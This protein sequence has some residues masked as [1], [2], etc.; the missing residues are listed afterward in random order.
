MFSFKTVTVDTSGNIIQ[1]AE[2]IAQ[3]QE[4]KLAPNVVLEMVLI[5][6]GSFIMGSPE[7]EVGRNWYQVWDQSL[8]GCNIEGPQHEVKVSDFWISKYPVTQ[9][10]WLAV[11]DLPQID[12]S[13]NPNPAHFKGDDHPVEQVSWYDAMEFCRRLSRHTQQLYRLPTEAEWEYSCRAGTVTPFN[14]GPTITADLAN[15]APIEGEHD[16]FQWSG[17]YLNE[18][19][20]LYRQQTTEVGIFP[21]NA[22][23]LYDMHGNV[24]EWC[25]DDWHPTYEGSPTD[26]SAW[27]SPDVDK[28][29]LRGGSWF[30]FPDL[31]R[32][33]FRNRRTPDTRLNRTGFRLVLSN[34]IH[35]V[36]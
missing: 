3:S 30:F 35:S 20:G 18:P 17:T 16:G 33:A 27:L 15:Y 32:S 8:D 29:I 31:C 13:L 22:F 1:T 6:G 24:W 9:S 10:Q 21:A 7:T 4:E 28:K 36:K 14:V 34:K 26:G 11:A 19:K 5:P 2:K 23:G 25:W 12:I